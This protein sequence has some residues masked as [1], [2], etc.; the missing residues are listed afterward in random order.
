MRINQ[1]A[2]RQ[3]VRLR[4]R[5]AVVEDHEVADAKAVPGVG[6][7]NRDAEIAWAV[8]LLDRNARTVT[9]DVAD[10]KRRAIVELA[11]IDGRRGLSRRRLIEAIAGSAGGRRSVLG[12]CV[13]ADAR[14]NG[15]R[16]AACRSGARF[17]WSAYW[18]G[19]GSL[20]GHDGHRGKLG[21]AALG[22][23]SARRRKQ[24]GLNGNDAHT[25]AG[26]TT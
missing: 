13:D 1:V 15:P 7:A 19:T 11:A 8:T 17:R 16:R 6:S 3:A 24:R 23:G 10:R 21:T 9:Q 5:K 14:R 2:A 4:H 18:F 22:K 25:T 20:R 12:R 26:M